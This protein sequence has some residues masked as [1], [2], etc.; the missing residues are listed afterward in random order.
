M[1]SSWQRVDITVANPLELLSA[2]LPISHHILPTFFC[3]NPPA[4]LKNIVS[5]AMGQRDFP[6]FHVEQTTRM[7]LS[8]ELLLGVMSKGIRMVKL[9]LYDPG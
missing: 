9:G 8:R 2:R 7:D 3:A 1:Q 6:Y 4:L 5:R